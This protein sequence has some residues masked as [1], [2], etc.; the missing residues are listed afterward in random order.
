MSVTFLL[1]S[2]HSVGYLGLRGIFTMDSLMATGTFMTLGSVLTFSPLTH[3]LVAQRPVGI[4]LEVD[5]A[6]V[7]LE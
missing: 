4:E 2:L 6:K 3:S 1:N 5:R 7:L